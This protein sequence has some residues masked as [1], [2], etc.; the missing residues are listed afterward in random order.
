MEVKRTLGRLTPSPKP[1]VALVPVTSGKQ[2][3]IQENEMRQVMLTFVR[4][5]GDEEAGR[6]GTGNHCD[7]EGKWVA[8]HSKDNG[9]MRRV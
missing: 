4:V 7:E 5:G 1:T 6:E 2:V 8:L 9:W 3:S